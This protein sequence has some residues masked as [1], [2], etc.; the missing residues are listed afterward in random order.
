MVVSLIGGAITFNNWYT[1]PLWVGLIF[2]VGEGFIPKD[3]TKR[4][5]EV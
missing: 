5:K 3:T 4:I 1:I 2:A